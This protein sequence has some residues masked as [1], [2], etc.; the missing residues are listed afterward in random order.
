MTHHMNPVIHFELPA[1]DRSRMAEFYTKTFGWKAKQ[2]GPEM[3]NYITVQTSEADENGFPKKPGMINGGLY[4]KTPDVNLPSVVIGVED[5]H[6]HM[7]KVK[8]AGGTV[9]GEPVEIPGVGMFVG[10]TDTEGNRLS[11]LQPSRKG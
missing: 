2:M 9:L 1:E 3:N 8:E 5:I 10:F 11:M 4:E 7:K 6:A